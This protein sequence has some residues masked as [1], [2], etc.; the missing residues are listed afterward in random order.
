MQRFPS[1]LRLVTQPF[2][3]LF[4][5]A[6]LAC[7]VGLPRQ[8]WAQAPAATIGLGFGVDSTAADVGPIV[9]LV[10]T[11]LAQ[12]DSTARARGLW[13]S[14]DRFDR[15]H[16]D[17]AGTVAYQGF[18]AT[19]VNVSS[20][21]PGDTLYVVKVL[22]A[23]GGDA[24]APPSPLA[25]ERLYAVRAPGA[26]HG[27]QLANALPHLTAGWRTLSVGRL[28]F[29][30]EPGQRIDRSRARRAARFV[31]VVS[32]SFAVARPGHIDY[33]V[34]SSPEAYF[35]ILGLDFFAGA[36]S[37]RV[38]TGGL[39]MARERMVLAGDPAQGEAYLHE[40]VHATIGGT[41]FGGSGFLNEGVAAWLG[42][43]RGRSARELYGELVRYQ[44]AQ[45]AATLMDLLRGEGSGDD[46]AVITDVLY[47]SGALVAA[48]VHGRGGM[49]ALRAMANAPTDPTALLAVVATALG[50]PNGDP[51]SLDRW[52]RSAAERAVQTPSPGWDIPVAR[53]RHAAVASR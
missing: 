44:Q 51:S 21:A 45:P 43:S 26:P 13:S 17:L 5:A 48:D 15:E 12:P 27:W 46:P 24:D 32:D 25:M 29:H 38:R 11:Y 3:R 40:L 19:I 14:A 2:P 22:H 20:V 50:L 23:R 9:R 33:Y 10:R 37:G 18:P 30:Y 53:R 41:Y 35:R 16:D 49:V 42:G 28:A 7:G 34:T 47:A 6:A 4:V 39:T 36:P 52:W 8:V 1:S 31:D